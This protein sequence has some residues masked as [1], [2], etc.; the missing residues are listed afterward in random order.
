MATGALLLKHHTGSSRSQLVRS[1]VSPHHLH[2]IIP[3]YGTYTWAKRYD[4]W[5]NS[6]AGHIALQGAH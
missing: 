6:K 2:L 3:A 1:C 4:A 5:Q